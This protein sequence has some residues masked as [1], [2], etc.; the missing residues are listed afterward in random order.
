MVCAVA[1]IIS[2]AAT[3]R[4]HSVSSAVT[5]PAVAMAGCGMLTGA[6]VTVVTYRSKTGR[7]SDRS[8]ERES[9]QHRG[10]SFEH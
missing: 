4:T 1:A 10:D 9:R 7:S 6:A 3:V 8:A 2:T 5:A